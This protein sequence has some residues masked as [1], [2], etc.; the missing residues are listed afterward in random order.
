MS[1][2]LLDAHLWWARVVW[3][4]GSRPSIKN[5]MIMIVCEWKYGYLAGRLCLAS[6]LRMFH[7]RW[8]QVKVTK[9]KK[10]LCNRSGPIDRSRRERVIQPTRELMT[11]TRARH[12][13]YFVCAFSLWLWILCVCTCVCCSLIALCVPCVF[14]CSYLDLT[15]YTS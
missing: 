12:A 4:F 1:E 5:G 3:T 15:V 11:C 13:S 8:P 14:V 6:Q 2:W 9:W 10:Q 7:G